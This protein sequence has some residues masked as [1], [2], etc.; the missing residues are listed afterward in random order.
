MIRNILIIVIILL[1]VSYFGVNVREVATSPTTQ[2]NFSY[3]TSVVIDVWNNYLKEP[4][5][6]IW[7]E[8]FVKLIWETAMANLRNGGPLVPLTSS[9]TPQL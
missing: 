7:N 2:Q 1:V 5:M 4:V 9:S 6:F 8:I 3:V